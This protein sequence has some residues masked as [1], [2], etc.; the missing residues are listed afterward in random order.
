M[1]IEELWNSLRRE[2][3]QSQR[4]VDGTHPLDLY[5]DFERPDRPGLILFC[6][7]RPNDPPALK[8]ISIERR[9]RRDGQ[10]SMRV[11]LEEP[12][13]LPVFAELCMDIIEFTRNAS[14]NAQPSGQVLSRIERWRNLMQSQPSRLSRN[15][16]IGLI[17]ELLVL[18]T[19]LVPVLGPDQAVSSWTG[20]LGTSQDFRLPDGRK[21]EVKALDPN[22][23]QVRVN[24][25]DQLDGGGDPLQL[26]IVR[27]EETGVDAKGAITA[28][29]LIERLRRSLSEAPNAL[30]AF[31]SL[32]SFA[33]WDDAA[34]SE[35][36]AVRLSRVEAY[37]VDA[38]FPRLT[39][40]TVPA[41][42]IEATYTIMLPPAPVI[43]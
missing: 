18:E 13:L 8:A 6:D 28:S 1:R 12:R 31:E 43:L 15:K 32:L 17:G 26:L 24:G 42:V 22:G 2:S 11:C 10:W 27:L 19:K 25:L 21:L 9:R 35:T 14:R 16:L 41:A 20:P 5:A 34:D 36:F 23:G 29:G 30:Q 33:G 39:P 37:E 3:L 38:D 40:A 7:E 4:R